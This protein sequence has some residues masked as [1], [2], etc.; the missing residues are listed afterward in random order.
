MSE[1]LYATAASRLFETGVSKNE[2]D[3]HSACV[4]IPVTPARES[5]EKEE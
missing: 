2:F 3:S 4:D 5:L 1:I